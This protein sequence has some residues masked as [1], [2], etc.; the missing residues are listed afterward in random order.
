MGK[1][2]RYEEKYDPNHSQECICHRSPMCR[3]LEE[4]P[5]GSY[6]DYEEYEKL[7]QRCAELE[8]ELTLST[9]QND[10]LL[11]EF[12]RVKL[13]TDN[14]EIHG[15]C[16]RAHVRM[17]QNVSV[18]DRNNKLVREVAELKHKVKQLRKEQASEYEF[19]EI[20]ET[21]WTPCDKDW[22]DYCQ[23]SPEHEA[24]LR[25]GKE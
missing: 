3:G 7:E 4:S 19:R 20:G 17:R 9:D 6:V 5:E 22:F 18:I 10:L 24:R 23:K 14:T 25:K 2:I 1:V 13:L 12:I 15:L 16:E 8:K 11:D 21:E